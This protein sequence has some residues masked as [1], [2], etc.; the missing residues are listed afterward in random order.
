MSECR[1]FGEPVQPSIELRG[2]H[3]Y[4]VFSLMMRSIGAHKGEMREKLA[5]NLKKGKFKLSGVERGDE[6]ADHLM[7]KVLSILKREVEKVKL[8][9][10]HDTICEK[11]P[12]KEKD[13]CRVLGKDWNGEFLSMVDRAV[14]EN[15]DGLLEVGGEYTPDYLIQNRT[16]IVRAIR[17]TLKDLPAIWKQSKELQ[18][19]ISKE[20]K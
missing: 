7:D 15:T 4:S 11:C 8:T 17:R 3:L 16:V 1:G 19:I 13:N 9:D 14:I 20:E 5:R 12:D 6:F 10:T 18:E 2:H